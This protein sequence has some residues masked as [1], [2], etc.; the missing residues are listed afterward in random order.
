[1]SYWIEVKKEDIE[2]DGDQINVWLES[3][4]SGNRYAT[5]KVQDLKDLLKEV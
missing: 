2:L 3:D 5:I 4:E 1:M